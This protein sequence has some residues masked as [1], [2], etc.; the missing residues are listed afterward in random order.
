MKTIK[1]TNLYLPSCIT[2]DETTLEQTNHNY[3][4]VDY[5]QRLHNEI[6]TDN[7]ISIYPL[8]DYSKKTIDGYI[9]SLLVNSFDLNDDI[10]ITSFEE[11]H[12]IPIGK[13]NIIIKFVNGINDNRIVSLISKLTLYYKDVYIVNFIYTNP[14]EDVYYVVC[15]EACHHDLPLGAYKNVDKQ[16]DSSGQ[17]SL[18][19][20]SETLV[21]NN[22]D[23]IT[24]INEN[25]ESIYMFLYACYFYWVN[26][27][28]ATINDNQNVL[29]NHFKTLKLL[30][31]VG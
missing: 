24:D 27:L 30:K 21:I 11:T 28:N 7:L 4:F 26:V 10:K 20:Q 2:F 1:L 3:I 16:I 29:A 5:L 17:Q 31:H 8:I 22:F 15:K 14:L 9:K 6:T 19:E 25:K 12:M 13:H 18:L 23:Y